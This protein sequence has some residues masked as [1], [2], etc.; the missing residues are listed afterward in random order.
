MSINN[1]FAC[2]ALNDHAAAN[3]DGWWEWTETSGFELKDLTVPK[4]VPLE[5]KPRVITI[6]L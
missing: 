6:D 5:K 2:Q 4:V 3:V 1:A